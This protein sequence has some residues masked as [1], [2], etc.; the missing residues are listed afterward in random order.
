MNTSTQVQGGGGLGLTVLGAGAVGLVVSL[1]VAMPMLMQQG[2]GA[3][4]LSNDGLAW[5]LPVVAYV[6]FATMSSGLALIAALAMVFGW[7]DF[8]PIA[9]R[10]I[11]LSV[12][13]LI[14][15][16]A[17]LALELGHPFRMLWAIPAGM[18]VASP[19]FWM[20][21]FYLIALVVV[22]LKFMKI[23]G[24]DWDSPASRQLGTV[25]VIAE[26]LAVCTLGFVFG[27]MA[28]RPFWSDGMMSVYFLV[29]GLL[30]GIALAVLMTYLSH[31]FSQDAMP[32]RVRALMTGAMPR[33]FAAVLGLVIVFVVFRKAVGLWSNADGLQVFAHMASSP[34]F[35]VQLWLGLVLPLWL[36]VNAG[37]RTNG[38]MQVLA[39][40]LVLLAMAL[41]R[42][43]YI[44]GGQL[45]PAFKGAWAGAMID[46]APSAAEWMLGLLAVSIVLML[47]GLGE[48]LF[49]L[50]D[51]PRS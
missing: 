24:G 43:E 45:V 26:I 19:L 17:S 15:G 38:N 6:Y 13:T 37:T 18:Q 1:I 32:E 29:S 41:G 3:F 16:F 28:M 44:I 25:A 11:W 12:A 31:G 27:S 7:K 34:L 35:H 36:L 48:K 9:K 23:N 22:A 8:Y 10:C 46:Y 30:S 21:V 2:H 39:A 50:G 47:Y 40:V 5:G 20:G 33:L 14:A 49:S 51:E 4:N 42:Y